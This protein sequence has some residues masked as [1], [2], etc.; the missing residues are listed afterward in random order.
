[1]N[2]N[3]TLVT[4]AAQPTAAELR[5]E[6]ILKN[7][8]KRLDILIGIKNSEHVQEPSNYLSVA[9]SQ[10]SP[11]FSEPNFNLNDEHLISV[12]PKTNT[13]IVS[14]ESNF[15][16]SNNMRKSSNSSSSSSSSSKSSSSKKKSNPT[17]LKE[18]MENKMP[19]PGSLPLTTIANNQIK[20]SFNGYSNKEI[21]IFFLIALCTSASFLFKQS[22]FIGQ[23]KFFFS[24]ITSDN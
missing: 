4:T 19:T 14:S 1:M 3:A 5:R 17:N 6:R 11:A 12:T 7:G 8:Q 15:L 22:Y 9:Q 24:T 13:K 20:C 21:L 23:V 10:A 18:P 16:E 2:L